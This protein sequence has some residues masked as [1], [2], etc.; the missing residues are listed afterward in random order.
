M[1]KESNME[2]IILST[3]IDNH[4][5]QFLENNERSVKFM[6]IDSDISE[7]LKDNENKEDESSK[8][9][10]LEILEKMFKEFISDE[11][12][13]IQVENLKTSTISGMI[14]LS[15]QSRRMQEMSKM[16]GGG[17]DMGSM[18]PTEE[19]LI[20]NKN[21]SLIKALLNF[22]NREEKKEDIKLICEHVFD[23]AKMSHKLLE[24]QVLTQFIE[25][26]NEI[27]MRLIKN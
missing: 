22:N 9:E 15:E 16:F 5:I 12:L 25:R 2:A 20:L 10:Q 14:L 21:N 11:K 27:L 1:Y 4:F 23:L 17:Q 19:T 24:P 18:F 6:R 26:S 13:K 7:S 3:M 8:K